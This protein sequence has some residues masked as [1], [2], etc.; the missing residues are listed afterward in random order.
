MAAAMNCDETD[1]T[2]DDEPGTQPRAQR[3]RSR[4]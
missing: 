1:L 3:A 2:W 4:K